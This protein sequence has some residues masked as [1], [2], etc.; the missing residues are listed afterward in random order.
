MASPDWLVIGLLFGGT[1]T[2][3][4]TIE[5]RERWNRWDVTNAGIVLLLI[6]AAYL[7]FTG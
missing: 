6:L 3:V 5:S 1:M 2:G 7:Y 4:Q